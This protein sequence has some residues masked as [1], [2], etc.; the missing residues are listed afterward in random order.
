MPVALYD[1]L[2]PDYSDPAALRGELD[3]TYQK[4][5]DC[6]LCV[7]L[8]PSFKSLFRMIDA[9]D[10]GATDVRVL[11]DAEQT[12]VVDEC[13]SASSVTWSARTPPRRGRTGGSTSP[14]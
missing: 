5:S 13:F 2:A 9:Y 8:C 4:C 11:T 7:R 3:R 1:P 12:R 6:R 10:D 14:V